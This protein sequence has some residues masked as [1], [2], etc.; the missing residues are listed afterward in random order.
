MPDI[1]EKPKKYTEP[2][3]TIKPVD[4]KNWAGSNKANETQGSKKG[5]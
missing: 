3:S 2:V 5:E 1:G 4:S